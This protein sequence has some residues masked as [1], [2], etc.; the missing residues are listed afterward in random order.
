MKGCIENLLPSNILISKD[1]SWYFKGAEMYR[2]DIVKYFYENLKHNEAG[3]YY[4]EL[5]N[6]MASVEVEDVPFVVKAVYRSRSEN[7]G[8]EF[9]EIVLNEDS[10]E[11]LLPE[12]LRVG[13]EN[14]LYC[15]VK[16][17]RF[18]ARFSRAG[19]YQ[20]SQYIEVEGDKDPSYYL[21]LN[22]LKYY[23]NIK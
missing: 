20:L 12:T 6:D 18:T 16:Q 22:G 1:G 5:E 17:N 21:L 11:E 23:I 13:D 8:K 10:R 3:R 4:I 19:Y 2:K 7:S 9:F 14:V 15:S